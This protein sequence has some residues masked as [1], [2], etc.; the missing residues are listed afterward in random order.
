MNLISKILN[1]NLTLE[2]DTLRIYPGI[3]DGR[4]LLDLFEIY[5]NSSNVFGYA[6]PIYDMKNFVNIMVDKISRHQNIINGFVLYFIELKES[7]KVIGF[8]NIILD[9][10]YNYRNER[11]YS[12]KNVTAEIII[13][14]TYWNRGL[15][16]QS[17]EIIF[18]Y[19]K[20]M[21][22]EN[23]CTFIQRNNSKAISLNKKLNFQEIDD[24]ALE[25]IYGYDPD[26]KIN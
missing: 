12:K 23:I 11:I 17:S 10:M 18:S 7:N 13:N 20:T 9:G 21:G 8:R 5:S 19:L 25:I 6:N 3:L 26:F 15:A 2:D 4:K 16:F 14:S 24:V 1:E 22:V